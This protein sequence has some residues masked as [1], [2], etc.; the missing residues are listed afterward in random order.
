MSS[1]VKLIQQNGVK[2]NTS[3]GNFK[4]NLAGNYLEEKRDLFLSKNDEFMI[5]SSNVNINTNNTTNQ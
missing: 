5:N 4:V 2:V 3:I 1:E